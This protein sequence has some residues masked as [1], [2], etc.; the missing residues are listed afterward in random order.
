MCE[1]Y[2]ANTKGY[3]HQCWLMSEQYNVNTH[4]YSHL[5]W[6]IP[7]QYNAENTPIHTYAG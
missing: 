2:N 3:L 5:C 1:Q 4:T 6:L 7:E